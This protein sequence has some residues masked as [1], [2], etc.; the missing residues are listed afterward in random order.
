M[1]FPGLLALSILMGVQPLRSRI[2]VKEIPSFTTSC[3]ET[4]LLAPC[5]SRR[6]PN[7]TMSTAWIDLLP[8]RERTLVEG[9]VNALQDLTIYKKASDEPGVDLPAI[10]VSY[11]IK[12]A[13]REEKTNKTG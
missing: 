1:T 8:R 13:R 12:N 10:F 2:E 11:L 9:L 5:R 7:W 3:L 6:Q 4:R